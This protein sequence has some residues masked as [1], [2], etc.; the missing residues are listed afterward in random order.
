MPPRDFSTRV[1]E[2]GS[3]TSLAASATELAELPQIEARAEAARAR[4]TQLRQQAEAASS[5]RVDRSGPEEAPVGQSAPTG[6]RR[7]RRPSRKALIV[8]AG[9]VVICG[10]LATSGLAVWHHHNVAQQRQRSADFATTARD[11]VVAMM[12]IRADKARDDMQHFADR[13][14]GTFKAS[15]LMGANDVVGDLEKSKVS[16]TA[17]VQAVAVQSM[18][19]DSA[20]VLVAAKSE[21][22]KPDQAKPQSRSWRVAVTVE[23]DG[24]QLKIS[25]VEFVP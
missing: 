12:S 17:T 22:T 6:R 24:G 13:T 10:S 3:P 7:L 14:T 4:A 11:G 1:L 2:T 15:V 18:T 9:L 20:V 8:I 25:K 16:T 19:N 23:R 21:I 5:D